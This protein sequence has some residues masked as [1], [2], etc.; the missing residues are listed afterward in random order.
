LPPEQLCGAQTVP[1]AQSR[2]APVPSQTPSVPQLVVGLA[3][4]SA[5]G[6]VPTKMAAHTP[7]IPPVS[8]AAHATQV[9]PQAP[10]QQ[11]P[12]TQLPLRQASAT[13]HAAP[14]LC[15]GTQAPAAQ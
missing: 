5:P 15:L 7:S 10:L 13:V 11:N 1:P 4:H 3:T 6:S 9:P 2:Q 12:S 14:L 8:A